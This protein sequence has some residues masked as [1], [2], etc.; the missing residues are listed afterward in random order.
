M[1]WGTDF[2][3]NDATWD[4]SRAKRYGHQNRIKDSLSLRRNSYRVLLTRSAD[5]MIL[6]LP[7]I[8]LLS[9]TREHLMKCG[10]TEL[11]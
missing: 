1:G 11:K 3:L 7:D 2:I 9:E 6:Y 8:E 10:I 5:G 4:H